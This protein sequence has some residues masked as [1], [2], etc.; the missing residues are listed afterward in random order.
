M[1]YDIIFESCP[2]YT[3]VVLLDEHGRLLMVRF[4]DPS[5]PYIEGAT[6]IGR[7]RHI[8]QGLNAAFVDIGDINDGLLPFKKLPKDMP[9]LT[10]GQKILVRIS[11]GAESEKGARLS[12]RVAYKMPKTIEK[13]PAILQAPPPALRRIL[14]DAGDTPVNCWIL[15]AR[16]RQ[17]VLEAVQEERI[18]QLDQHPNVGLLEAVDAQL[19]DI[20]YPSYD[21]P[22]GGSITVEMTKALSS[23]DVDSGQ[24]EGNYAEEVLALNLRAAEEVQRLSRLLDLGGNIIVD[25]VTMRKPAHRKKVEDHIKQAFALH[26]P[27]KVEVLP[28]SRFGLM[29]INR[30]RSGP[31]LPKL[32]RDPNDVAG[33]ISL[34]LWRNHIGLGEIR[35][36]V[37]N[38]VA[39]ILKNHLTTNVALAHL[40]RPVTIKAKTDFKVNQYRVV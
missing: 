13:I 39:D 11:R 35:V 37:A 20:D 38:D 31:M 8:S 23:I 4:D 33:R 18:F 7:V 32:L 16:T 36:E 15:D 22:G 29:E 25:F 26:D 27:Q 6:I 17:Q 10:E 5:R 30:Q 1:A 40:G 24:I 21:L 14:M 19:E 12:A 28:M 9:K 3:R 2:W 34:E